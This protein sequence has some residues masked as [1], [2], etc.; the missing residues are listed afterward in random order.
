MFTLLLHPVLR[1]FLKQHAHIFTNLLTTVLFFQESLK[2]SLQTPPLLLEGVREQHPLL[3]LKILEN[4]A[5]IGAS[6]KHP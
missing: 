3:I 4:L 6:A 5:S 2:D 1:N